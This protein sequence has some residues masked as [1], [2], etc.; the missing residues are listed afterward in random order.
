MFFLI[1][2]YLASKEICIRPTTIRTTTTTKDTLAIHSVRPGTFSSSSSVLAMTI[3]TAPS[4]LPSSPS[5]L[6]LPDFCPNPAS[7]AALRSTHSARHTVIRIGR[8]IVYCTNGNQK[9]EQ[10]PGDNRVKRG[11]N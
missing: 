1:L 5:R 11:F 6:P 3:P 10:L 4:F 7:M 9:K 8:I 2:Y